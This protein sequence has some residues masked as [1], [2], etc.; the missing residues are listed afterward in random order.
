VLNLIARLRYVTRGFQATSID[1]P[2]C[3]W[4]LENLN[5]DGTRPQES[6]ALIRLRA[7]R[8]FTVSFIGVNA[9][10]WE[11]IHQ[12]SPVW[13]PPPWDDILLDATAALPRIGTAVVL[14]A[15]ALEVFIAHVLDDLAAKGKVPTDVWQWV[16]DRKD[17]DKDPS[18]EEQFDVLL[19]HFVGHSLKED[20]TLWAAFPNLRAARNKFV[21]EGVARVEKNLGIERSGATRLTE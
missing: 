19:K 1:F 21:H 3:T 5:D 16:N 8:R 14:A 12:L 18:T 17:P 7:G 20:P 2:R 4:K 13:A 10:V 11:H 6:D 9:A 15:T